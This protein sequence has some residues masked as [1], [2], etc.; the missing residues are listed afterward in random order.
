MLRHFEKPSDPNVLVGFDFADDAGVYKLRDDLAIISTVDVFT[1]VVD[2]AYEWGQIGAANSLS[3]VY[4]MG[5]QV[6]SALNIVGFPRN[7]LDFEVLEDL[8]RGAADKAKEAGCVILG[9][10]TVDTPEPLFGMAVIGTIHPDRVVANIGAKPG[11]ALIL[12][13]PIGTGIISHAI[14]EEKATAAVAAAA[15]KTMATLNKVAAECMQEIGA[16]ACTD[17]TGFGLLGHA[18]EM[19]RG[20]GVQI[21]IF[22]SKVPLL[23]AV[24]ELRKAG[25]V[26][27]GGERNRQYAMKSD[28][29]IAAEISS[30]L[31]DVLVDP[32]T[33]GGLFIAVENNNAARLL[34][35]LHARGVEEARVVGEVTEGAAGVVCAP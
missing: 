4:A 14:K 33:S 32:Q 12:T 21:H 25:M 1:P 7:R 17:I 27:I 16:H 35:L 9:G 3:D 11:D 18:Y 2:D 10:H 5:G 30:E 31:L 28:S 13:K 8:L 26:T 34:E 19:A 15:T 20:S 23:P 22:A 29:A 6:L 24:L